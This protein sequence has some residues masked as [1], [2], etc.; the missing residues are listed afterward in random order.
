MRLTRSKPSCPGWRSL[1]CRAASERA[2]AQSSLSA[3]RGA[4]VAVLP[5]NKLAT[6]VRS[7]C[8]RAAGHVQREP[9]STRRFHVVRRLAASAP[10]HSCTFTRRPASG[11]ARTPGSE[12][13]IKE[14]GTG[15]RKSIENSKWR[16]GAQLRFPCRFLRKGPQIQGSQ[17]H[18][19][20][21]H[22]RQPGDFAAR[23]AFRSFPCRV[24]PSMIRSTPIADHKRYS[25]K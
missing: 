14:D 13:K 18:H 16:G 15:R 8:F 10:F 4:P 9:E 20:I 6:A 19:A 17:Q 7:L 2:S 12:G 25:G 22:A 24:R 23:R 5:A 3:A 11:A 21:E 1:R